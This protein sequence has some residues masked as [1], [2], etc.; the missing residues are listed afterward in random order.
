[1][2]QSALC[3]YAVTLDDSTQGS[4]KLT[5]LPYKAGTNVFA[6]SGDWTPGAGDFKVAKCVTG[7]DVGSEASIGTAPTWVNGRVVIILSGTELTCRKLTIRIENAAI[8]SEEILVETYGHANAQYP[9]DYADVVAMGMTNLNATITSRMATFTQPAGFLAATFPGGTIAN[10]T[11]ITA[12]TITTVTNLTNAPTNGDF[13]AAMKTSIG[14]A[15][16]SA[17]TANTSIVA[18]KAKTDQLIFTGAGWLKSDVQTWLGVAPLALSSQKVQA[19]ATAS[20]GPSDIEDIT[21]GVLG[22]STLARSPGPDTLGLFPFDGNG[23]DSTG[24]QNATLH[25]SP[26]YGS[27][28]GGIPGQ[29][30]V[31][32]G[33]SQYATVADL[34][35]TPDAKGFSIG[36]RFRPGTTYTAGSTARL[37]TKWFKAPVGAP[38]NGID[39]FLDIDD[40]TMCAQL[41]ANDLVVRQVFSRTTTWTSGVDYDVAVTFEPG[42]LRLWINGQIEGWDRTDTAWPAYDGTATPFTLGAYNTGSS[43]SNF[44]HGSFDDVW[45]RHGVALTEEIQAFHAGAVYRFGQ[46]ESGRLASVPRRTLLLPTGGSNWDGDAVLEPTNTVLLSDGATR[47]AA[48][49]GFLNATNH[50]SVGLVTVTTDGDGET[51][52]RR[53]SSQAVG[54][55]H[56]GESGDAN[57]SCLLKAPGSDRLYLYYTP[58]YTD[59]SSLLLATSDDDGVTWTS[60]GVVLDHAQGWAAALANPAVVIDPITGV[61]LMLFQG[62]AGSVYKT[63]LARCPSGDGVTWV[64][65]PRNPLESLSLGGETGPRSFARISGQWHAWGHAS[66]HPSNLP[67]FVVDWISND[68]VNWSAADPAGPLLFPD[69][70]DNGHGIG[71]QVADSTVQAYDGRV[72]H[73][74]DVDRDNMGTFYSFIQGLAWPGT[75]E[76]LVSGPAAPTQLGRTVTEVSALL[77]QSR[78]LV[79]RPVSAVPAKVPDALKLAPSAGS[80]AAGSAMDKLANLDVAVTTRATPDDVTGGTVVITPYL[81]VSTNP[82]HTTKDVAAI[83]A[84][85]TP[86]DFWVVKDAAGSPVDLSAK[87]VRLVGVTV[88]AGDDPVGPFDDTFTAAWQYQTGGGGITIGGSDHNTVTVQYD[89]AKTATAGAYQYWL[90]NVTDKTVLATGAFTIKPAPAGLFT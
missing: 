33:S 71:N 16:D 48:Y 70:T 66:V 4:R 61:W 42:S 10:T 6:A 79:D 88:D 90:V 72:F 64:V 53:G 35:S 25:G 34:L 60:R 26:T 83:F 23:T 2:G 19:D 86:T 80:P 12:G 65:D 11:N 41:Y 31:L 38:F 89:A 82:R 49:T 15:A 84:G 39:I 55:G 40:G 27:A 14:T 68:M 29:S 75:L 13:T 5:L 59:H 20:R 74:Y 43:Q 22:I 81:A 45:V 77:N 73:R 78:M 57:G 85:S 58:G 32:N 1:M 76:E 36:F 37:V 87:T 50:T 69:L 47:I 3:K 17:V 8:N 67:T 24:L 28:I 63:G 7:S 52:T 56:G 21:A 30:L 9:G 46:A 44:F 51:W 54:N 62:S 18:V